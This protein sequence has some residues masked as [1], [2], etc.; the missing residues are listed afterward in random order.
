[1]E[2]L[3]INVWP[4]LHGI[5]LAT[6]VLKLGSL[7]NPGISEETQKDFAFRSGGW[8]PSSRTL[9]YFGSFV[10]V[11]PKV[12]IIASIVV[13]KAPCLLQTKINMMKVY[14]C[15]CLI[16]IAFCLNAQEVRI[17]LTATTDYSKPKYNIENVLSN[18]DRIVPF[19]LGYSFVLQAEQVVSNQFSWYGG[20]GYTKKNFRPQE[21]KIDYFSTI[22]SSGGAII[23][24]VGIKN[25]NP[26]KHQFHL[27]SVP[28]GIKFRPNRDKKLQPYFELGLTSDFQFSETEIYQ[29]EDLEDFFIYDPITLSLI[30]TTNEEEVY[31]KN[32][33]D[34]F[35]SAI[36]FGAGFEM[37]FN[38]S[39][40]LFLHC[41]TN[42]VEYRKANER[43]L[44]PGIKLWDNSLLALG[45]LSI[46]L[47]LQRAF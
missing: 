43:L 9:P 11:E 46:G 36:T 15:T 19:A 40:A 41:Q 5:G 35:G 4:D 24:F 25:L 1:V 2:K 39:Y 22:V 17:N 23:S 8:K 6:G 42:V 14:L 18:E 29:S 10:E 38:D 20:L 26:E 21:G 32:S 45:E 12:F 47:G 16:A 28:I 37:A 34:Y 3:L 7:T 27:M 33:F 44:S 13:D 31:T 30:P